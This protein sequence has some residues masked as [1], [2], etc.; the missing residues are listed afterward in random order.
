MDPRM[1]PTNFSSEGP[2][3]SSADCRTCGSSLLECA[4]HFGHIELA[5]CVFHPGTS[6]VI[7]M[8]SDCPLLPFTSVHRVHQ[9]SKKG[10]TMCLRQMRQ[11]EDASG[12][13]I[14]IHR[15][16]DFIQVTVTHTYRILAL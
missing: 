8:V 15:L 3:E 4:G 5:E 7:N 16:V 6:L 11:I 10:S 13:S 1:G 2:E 9:E 12:V 14:D